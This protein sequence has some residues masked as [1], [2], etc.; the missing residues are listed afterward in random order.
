MHDGRLDELRS[1]SGSYAADIWQVVNPAGMGTIY[2][3]GCYPVSLLHLVIQA[4]GGEA[5]F[6]DRRLTAVGNRLNSGGNVCDAAMAVRFANGVLATL[7]STDN[8]GD[9]SSFAITGT[10]GVLSFETNPW[11]PVA[12]DNVMTWRPF[13]PE[14]D[15]PEPIVVRSGHDAFH[16]QIKLVERCLEAGLTEASRPSP[17]LRDSLEIMGMLTEWEAACSA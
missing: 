11:L 5:V 17:R 6:S 4:T 15:E 14:Y 16:H 12:G 10:N 8:Y 9:S 1:I 2:N 7:Q 13:G 3:L